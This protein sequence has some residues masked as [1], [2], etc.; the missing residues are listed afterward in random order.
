MGVARGIGRALRQRQEWDRQS[1]HERLQREHMRRSE[2]REARNE[3]RQSIHDALRREQHDWQR[4]AVQRNEEEY[5]RQRLGQGQQ[6]AEQRKFRF[7]ADLEDMEDVAPPSG[8]IGGGAADDA[9]KTAARQ[10]LIRRYGKGK[11]D[12]FDFSDDGGIEF[13]R[14]KQP[15]GRISGGE[16]NAVRETL[17]RQAEETNLARRG[18]MAAVEKAEGDAA[19]IRNQPER[20]AHEKRNK[21]AESIQKQIDALDRQIAD[22]EDALANG[23]LSLD[24]P[25]KNRLATLKRQRE[26]VQRK[27]EEHN[28]AEYARQAQVAPDKF[29]ALMKAKGWTAEQTFQAIMKRLNSQQ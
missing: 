16:R 3:E 28:L 15:V 18:K 24:V 29:Q 6:E 13:Y 21:D 26:N 5:R 23:D 7:L 9:A 1:R 4:G 25:P 20:A 8:G 17:K 12:D 10:D 11:W 27:V 14:E 19:N 22:A 2:D